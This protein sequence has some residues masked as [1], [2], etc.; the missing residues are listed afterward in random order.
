MVPG[1]VGRDPWKADEAYSFGLVL[2]MVQTGDFVVPTLGSDPF[3]EKPPIFYITSAFFTKLFSPPLEMHVAARASCVFYMLLALAAV[4]L[5]SR[6]V[7]GPGTGWLAAL[8]LIGSVGLVHTA[9][10]LMTDV[11]LVA[12][13][14]LGLYGLLLGARMPWVGGLICGTGAGLALLSKGLIGP[15]ALGVT[16]LCLPLFKSWRWKAYAQLLGGIGLAVLPWLTIWPLALYRRSPTLFMEWFWDNNLGRFLGKSAIAGDKP[17]SR[18]FYFGVL[19]VFGLPSLPL[20]VWRLWKGLESRQAGSP[21]LQDPRLPT[22]VLASVVLFGVLSSSWQKRSL[23]A[24]PLLAP[25]AILGAGGLRC[26]IPDRAA[27]ML[28]CGLAWLFST[29]AFI[30][31]F[32]W[33]AQFTGWPPMALSRIHA[34]LPDYLP[35]F[36]VTEFLVALLATAGWT[37]LLLRHQRAADFLAIHWASGAALLYLLVMTLWLPVVNGNM[38]YRRDFDGLR[39]TLGTDPGVIS[40][41]NLGEPQRAMIHYYAGIKPL[42]EETRGKVDCRWMLIEGV[43]HEGE[44]PQPP[45]KNWHLAWKGR[46]HRELFCLYRREDSP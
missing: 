2:N 30:F 5:S 4:G 6:E 24:T 12:G 35:S 14:A 27:R 9:H 11:S 46:H 22:V 34:V 38:T 42:R 32:A 23:Y 44:R 33:L 29:A 16:V 1:L 10:M 45:D 18:F 40:S 43:D 13:Y 17:T 21:L 15:G 37:A 36:H 19:L 31:W 39:K 25:L 20:A 8:L 28:N 3:M 26:G 41:R 7:N